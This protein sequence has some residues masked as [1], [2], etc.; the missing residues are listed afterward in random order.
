MHLN[1]VHRAKADP[2]LQSTLE[3][4]HG[5]E[6]LRA[7]VRLHVRPPD[8]EGEPQPSQFPSRRAWREALIAAQQHRM[9]TE[10]QRPLEALQALRLRTRASRI[11][12]TVIVEGTAESIRDA[13]EIA[14]VVA[15]T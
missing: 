7:I 11:S 3:Q 14:E 2:S 13:L 15:A 5:D 10:L 1:S 8:R 6:Q 12:P 9:A 4:A